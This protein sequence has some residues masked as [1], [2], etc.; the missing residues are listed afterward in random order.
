MPIDTPQEMVVNTTALITTS[1][2]TPTSANQNFLLGLFTTVYNEL[3][4]IVSISGVGYSGYSGE[5]GEQGYSGYSGT[6]GI[7]GANGASGYSGYSGGT[8]SNGSSGY[9]GYSGGSGY[10]GASGTPALPGNASYGEMTINAN[11]TATSI[12]SANNFYQFT[13]GWV[14][15]DNNG[16]HFNTDQIVAD[17]AGAFETLCTISITCSLGNQNLIVQIFQNGT[18]ITDHIVE[19]NMENANKVTP[20]TIT[21]IL[22][23]VNIGDY[24]DVRIEN[25]TS[26]VTTVTAEYANFSMI[27]VQGATGASGNSGIS[28]Y[29]GYSGSGYSGYS[30]GSGYSGYSGTSGYSG[31]SGYSGSGT[32]GYSGGSGYSGY[33]GFNAQASGYSGYSGT[34]GYSGYSGYSGQSGYSGYSGENGSG[35]IGG[36]YES[37]YLAKNSSTDYDVSW[38]GGHISI[39]ITGLATIDLTTLTE[40]N[41]YLTSTNTSESISAIINGVPDHAYTLSPSGNLVVTFNATQTPLTSAGQLAMFN[42][43][44]ILYG[45]KGENICFA[46]MLGLYGYYQQY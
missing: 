37:Q 10:S 36:G 21:G 19:V 26:S 13:A 16:M 27:A 4:G 43:S 22:G 12:V 3:S 30:G 18:G 44:E 5:Q 24:F 7:I 9:S 46:Q 40:N 8:G 1:G 35:V 38:Q 11:S 20:V 41:I 39:N 31:Y 25:L 42:S 17:T 33:S 34:S 28:G 6:N 32:S 15:G 14:A 45:L 29:S 2:F 23:T